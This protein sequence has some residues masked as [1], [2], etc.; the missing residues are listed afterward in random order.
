MDYDDEITRSWKETERRFYA[1]EEALEEKEKFDYHD[2]LDTPESQVLFDACIPRLAPFITDELRKPIDPPGLGKT[3]RLLDQ[4][5]P[6]V[7]AT[8]AL[9][10]LLASPAIRND[11]DDDYEDWERMI[12]TR[13]QIG[14]AIL[15]ECRRNEWRRKIFTPRRER[16]RGKPP[17]IDP[18]SGSART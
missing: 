12:K 4:R 6:N 15:S 18:A 14:Q 2:Y 16:R 5:A 8:S 13:E 3:L 10:A 17:V 1:R 11:D 9:A 7:I